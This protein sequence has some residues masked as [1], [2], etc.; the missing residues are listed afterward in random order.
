MIGILSKPRV[1]SQFRVA[2]HPGRGGNPP[3]TS[4]TGSS[5]GCTTVA[6]KCPGEGPVRIATEAPALDGRFWTD[7]EADAFLA[8]SSD[9]GV[10]DNLATRLGAITVDENRLR[11]LMELARTRGFEFDD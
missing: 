7:S 8:H 4:R 3:I 9:R 6:D 10:L 1:G 2:R 11:K 5:V